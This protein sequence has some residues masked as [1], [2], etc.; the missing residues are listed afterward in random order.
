MKTLC[1]DISRFS[2]YTMVTVKRETQTKTKETKRF[3]L[4]FKLFKAVN[5][6]VN[7]CNHH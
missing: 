1:N 4:I 3:S 2:P 7:L 5:Q 6:F